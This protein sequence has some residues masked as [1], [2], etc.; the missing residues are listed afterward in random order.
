M[1]NGCSKIKAIP[2]LNYRADYTLCIHIDDHIFKL[3]NREYTLVLKILAIEQQQQQNNEAKGCKE[4][5][6][7]TGIGADLRGRCR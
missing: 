1:H 5:S 2:R 6:R 7:T 3:E 4:K